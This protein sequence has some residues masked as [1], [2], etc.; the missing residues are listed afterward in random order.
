MRLP[1]WIIHARNVLGTM[2]V[3]D[4]RGNIIIEGPRTTQLERLAWAKLFGRDRVISN[5]VY[6]K[7]D[8]ENWTN[9][10]GG[11]S[12]DTYGIPSLIAVCE[13]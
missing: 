1:G 10:S 11:I 5:P 3:N 9:L 13:D 2:I 4:S 8:L 7:V 6:H 12:S